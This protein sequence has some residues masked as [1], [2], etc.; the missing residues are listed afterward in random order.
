MFH[1]SFRMYVN[2]LAVSRAAAFVFVSFCFVFNTS[3]LGEFLSRSQKNA[4]VYG[5]PTQQ[6]WCASPFYLMLPIYYKKNAYCKKKKKGS[7]HSVAFSLRMVNSS[8]TVQLLPIAFS[9][10]TFW[11]LLSCYLKINRL[12]YRQTHQKEVVL[13]TTPL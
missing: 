9:Y 2:F 4:L 1:N 3:L 13:L 5:V 12:I 7:L 8:I 6:G 10:Y 11:G